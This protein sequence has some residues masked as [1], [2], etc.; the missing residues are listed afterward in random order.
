MK[1]AKRPPASPASAA[2]IVKASRLA[3]ITSR[4]TAA[5][6]GSLSRTAISVRPTG[7]RTSRDVA[8]TV[9]TRKNS[10]R[11]ER[12]MVESKLIGPIGPGPGMPM[13]PM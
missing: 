9:T 3:A 5:A 1:P 6:S 10:A 13:T 4:P 7:E 11:Y 12:A 2:E 8:T